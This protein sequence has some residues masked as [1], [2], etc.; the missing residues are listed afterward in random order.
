MKLLILVI[1]SLFFSSDITLDKLLNNQIILI[2]EYH[3]FTK[4]DSIQYQIINKVISNNK[5]KHYDILIEYPP[6]L[7]Y[8]IIKRDTIGI[9]NYFIYNK[10]NHFSSKEMSILNKMR[11]TFIKKLYDIDVNNNHITL[12]CINTHYTLRPIYYTALRIISKYNIF[13]KYFIQDISNILRL[14][15][16]SSSN[17]NTFNSLKEFFR[18]NESLMK[19]NIEKY[20]YNTLTTIFNTPI[21]NFN[22]YRS[23][24]RD[25]YMFEQI[26]KQYSTDTQIIVILGNA[27]VKKTNIKN[28]QYLLSIKY[29]RFYNKKVSTIGV[30]N[31]ESDSLSYSN[32]FDYIIVNKTGELVFK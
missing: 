10:D 16:I 28:V 11:Y 32:Y 17:I 1:A 6:E 19:K 4:N 12:N 2:G 29:D 3:Y 15:T 21:Y 9:R 30:V 31:T 23:I 25:S 5:F 13:P 18:K 7:E 14:S 8:F 20:D 22:N 27:H 24:E 26:K